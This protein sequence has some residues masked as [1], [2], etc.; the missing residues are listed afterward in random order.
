MTWVWV[1][2]FLL[3]RQWLYINHEIS[4][5]ISIEQEVWLER[6]QLKLEEEVEQKPNV[7]SHENM[8]G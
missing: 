2:L 4:S 3:V 1:N 8:A 6:S 5:E 7:R